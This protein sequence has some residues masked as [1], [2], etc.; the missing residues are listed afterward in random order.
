M[1]SCTDYILNE[2][3]YENGN[4]TICIYKTPKQVL[5]NISE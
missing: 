5:S 3:I 1:S 4:K 2:Q